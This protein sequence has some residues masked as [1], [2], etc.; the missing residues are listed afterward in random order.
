VVYSGDLFTPEGVSA[1][2][3]AHPS[4]KAVMLGRGLLA[5]P[6]LGATVMDGAP[7][8][9]DRLLDFHQDLYGRY[10]EVLFGEKPVLHKMKELWHYM[11]CLFPDHEKHAKRLR[12]SQTLGD[13]EAAVSAIFRDLALSPETGYLP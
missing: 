12:K 10:Q 3:K 4:S 2:V 13:Y 5:N 1:F 11:I 7:L 8:T 9:E 6:G